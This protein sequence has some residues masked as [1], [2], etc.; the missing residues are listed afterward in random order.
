M[1]SEKS[2][3]GKKKKR[4]TGREENKIESRGEKEIARWA[5]RKREE[6]KRMMRKRR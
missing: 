3:V 5:G 2:T 1:K 6:E 4:V